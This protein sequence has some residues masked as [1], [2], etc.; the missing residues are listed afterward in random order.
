VSVEIKDVVQVLP[1]VSTL[2]TAVKILSSMITP[3]LL[4]SASG[5]FVISTSSR[6]GR[7]VDRMRTLTERYEQLLERLDRDTQTEQRLTHTDWQLR[8][9]TRRLMLL[10][11]AL[12][13]FYL[14][15]TAF[16]LTSISMAILSVWGLKFAWVPVAMGMFGAVCMMIGCFSMVLEAQTATTMT[17]RE[18]ELVQELVLTR[19]VHEVDV[20]R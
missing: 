16:V 4:I 10:H 19:K 5:T 13:Q 7:V 17:R 6:L 2:D 1:N 18:A 12:N 15:S 11:R 9:Q 20:R 3:A 14:C 8:M